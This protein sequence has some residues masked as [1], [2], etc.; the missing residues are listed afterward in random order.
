M[1]VRIT[2]SNYLANTYKNNKLNTRMLSYPLQKEKKYR[3]RI[4]QIKQNKSRMG[5]FTNHKYVSRILKVKLL[6]GLALREEN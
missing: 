2:L 5:Y 6:S 3:K 4:L 1:V